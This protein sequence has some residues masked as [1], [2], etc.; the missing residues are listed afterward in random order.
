MG[1]QTSAIIGVASIG[2][3]FG[4]GWMV[5]GW[6]WEAKF[7]EMQSATIQVYEKKQKELNAQF[8]EQLERDTT[9]RMALSQMLQQ[10]RSKAASLEIEL[11][12]LSLSPSSPQIET[13]V[14]AG[15][16]KNGEEQPAVVIANPFSP[17][18]VRLWNTSAIGVIAGE[19]A[20]P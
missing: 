20:P 5:N 6:R 7:A 12:T 19:T 4:S 14:L 11:E 16:C 2:I 17:D 1:L 18:F 15:E 10:T 9:A 3:G 13:V 8:A